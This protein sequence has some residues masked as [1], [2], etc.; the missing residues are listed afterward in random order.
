MEKELCDAK[1]EVIHTR[2]SHIEKECTSMRDDVKYVSILAEKS[3]QLADTLEVVSKSMEVI[4]QQALEIVKLQNQYDQ[5][6]KENL[7]ERVRHLEKYFWMAV[8]AGS[9][10]M[11]LAKPIA[12]KFGINL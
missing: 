3:A 1:H 11:F 4:H 2:I 12:A 9:F 10:I 6:E 5:L 7:P 8:G